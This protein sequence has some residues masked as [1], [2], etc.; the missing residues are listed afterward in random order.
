MFYNSTRLGEKMAFETLAQAL[1]AR[2]SMARRRG[3]RLRRLRA[4]QN[5]GSWYLTKMTRGQQED[6]E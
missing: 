4:Y 1:H 3:R 5:N 6:F 2:S